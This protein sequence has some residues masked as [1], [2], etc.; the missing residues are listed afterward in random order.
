VA[1]PAHSRPWPLIQFRNQFFTDGRNPWTSDQPVAR[2]VPKHRTTQTQNKS[3]H[4]ANIHAL[5]RIRT[6]DP[7]VRAS[8]DSSC[9][10]PR[11]YC[12]RLA[13]ERAKTVH[14][15]DR[16][17]TGDRYQNTSIQ[18]LTFGNKTEKNL[19]MYENINT[20]YETMKQ[21]LSS[22]I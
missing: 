15:L 7:S 9:H 21:S 13:S 6:H 18:Q 1:L 2:P 22:V 4:I 16:A 20:V 12:D 10:R 8:E 19:L 11:G 14:A 17:T 3:I 5:G